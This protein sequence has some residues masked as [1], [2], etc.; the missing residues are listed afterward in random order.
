[1]CTAGRIKHHLANNIGRPE[2]SVVFVGY[3]GVGTLGREIMGK[4]KKVR[5]HRKYHTVRAAIHQI[6]GLSAHAD[7]TGLLDWLGHFKKPERIF[8]THGDEDA[9][10]ALAKEIRTRCSYDVTVPEYQ[11]AVELG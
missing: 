10:E 11:D 6:H 1:M 4:K 5:I 2:C 3:Q 7:R 8:L 9:A